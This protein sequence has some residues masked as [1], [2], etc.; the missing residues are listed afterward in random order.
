MGQPSRSWFERIVPVSDRYAGLPTPAAFTWSAAA[1]HAPV[2]EWYL[3]VFRSIRRPEAEEDRLTAHDDWA[4]REAMHAPGFV[5]YVKGPLQADGWCISFCLWASRSEA[6]SASGRPAHAD[7]AAIV[8]EMYEE[9]R[10]EF[11]RLRKTEPAGGFVF[12][13]YDRLATIAAP[14]GRISTATG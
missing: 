2:G 11:V 3:V 4:H 9:Y 5:H 7:A 10:L 14:A 1:G 12:E 8:G 13:P 6:R